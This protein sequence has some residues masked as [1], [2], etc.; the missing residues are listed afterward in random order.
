MDIKCERCDAAIPAENVNI[1]ALVAKC[2]ICNAVFGITGVGGG[3]QSVPRRA[4]VA[5]PTSIT[6]TDNGRELSIT[7]K[8]FTYTAFFLVFFSLF[9]NG[10]VSVFV[11]GAITSGEW[12]MLLFISLHLTVGVCIAYYTLCLFVNKTRITVTR[13]YLSV[14]HG[15]LP[16]FGN[17]KLAASKVD[18]IWCKLHV[19]RNKNGTTIT[20][21][22]HANSTHG[23]SK[24]LIGGLNKPEEALFVEQQIETFLKIEDKPVVGAFIGT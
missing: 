20:Y 16:W 12:I 8:W 3:G 15:P 23:K 18:Q 11:V 17:S 10:I 19:Q 24:K 5:M 9:W 21:Q 4:E 6:M 2:N 14:K 22:V 13:D 1:N 7:R